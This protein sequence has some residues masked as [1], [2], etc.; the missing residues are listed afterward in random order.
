MQKKRRPL[1]SQYGGISWRIPSPMRVMRFVPSLGEQYNTTN[2]TFSRLCFAII[3][4]INTASS[5]ATITAITTTLPHRKQQLAF[6]SSSA[7]AQAAAASSLVGRNAYKVAT[8]SQGTDA[9]LKAGIDTLGI[10]GPSTVHKNLTF[11]E[12]FDHEA[13]NKEGVVAKAEYGDTFTVDTGKYTGRSPKDRF[14]VVNPGSE[15]EA[16]IDWNSINQPTNP[17]VYE[18]L[19]NKAVAHFNT[20]ETAYVFDGYAGA[21][22][23]TRKKIRFVHE[24]AW[25]Q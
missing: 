6:K 15:T 11:Q 12:L 8:T 2:P 22:P 23:E 7:A 19:Y 21:N 9:C 5:I 13:K 25:Q 10:T 16:N 3:F 4:Q 14:I 24:T 20:C 1:D 17:E 18:E